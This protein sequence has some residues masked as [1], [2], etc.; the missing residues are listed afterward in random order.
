MP[1]A[2]SRTTSQS[3]L[4]LVTAPCVVMIGS[5][6]FLLIRD[7]QRAG[8]LLRWETGGDTEHRPDCSQRLGQVGTLVGGWAFA[9][10]GF[11]A[12]GRSRVVA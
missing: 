8:T 4:F 1:S 10:V 2:V 11:A 7:S 5:P 6:A 3:R 9:D 12:V